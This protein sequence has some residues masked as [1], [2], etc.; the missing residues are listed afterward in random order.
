[1]EQ[2]DRLSFPSFQ[3]D[4]KTG[5]NYFPQNVCPKDYAKLQEQLKPL[6]TDPVEVRDSEVWVDL[7]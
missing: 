3:Y 1:V 7:R 6:K 4:I 5:R 2:S